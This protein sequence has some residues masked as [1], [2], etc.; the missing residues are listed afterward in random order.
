[1]SAVRSAPHHHPQR[2]AK[3]TRRRFFKQSVERCHQTFRPLAAVSL[4]VWEL[5]RQEPIKL[6]TPDHQIVDTPLL[7]WSQ[8]VGSDCLVFDLIR[9]PSVR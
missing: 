7:V 6:L 3:L 9:E 1:M 8:R 4:V 2:Y 5:F